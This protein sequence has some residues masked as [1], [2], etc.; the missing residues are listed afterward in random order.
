MK[1]DKKRR[2]EYELDVIQDELEERIGEH[3]FVNE[4]GNVERFIDLDTN[5]VFVETTIKRKA[6]E[7]EK[8]LYERKKEIL[9]EFREDY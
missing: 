7:E 8:R 3:S 6:T 2:L 4:D 5:D 9:K 1:K